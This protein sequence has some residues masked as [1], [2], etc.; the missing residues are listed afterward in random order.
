MI[1][2]DSS[3]V[4]ADVLTENR[5]PSAEFWRQSLVSSRLLQF[6]VWNRIHVRASAQAQSDR[7]TALLARV[8]M[9]DLTERVLARALK[10]FPIHV[11]TLDALH[12]ATM[13]FLRTEGQE[14]ELATYDRRLAAAAG[15]LGIALYAL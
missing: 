7:A 14:I 4:L 12:L 6:E 10:P 13:E 9:L 15:A 1:Y 11:R 5:T 8:D 3:V 2:V